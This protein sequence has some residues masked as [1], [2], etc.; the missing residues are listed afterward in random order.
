M[1]TYEFEVLLAPDTVMDEDLADRLFE[2]GCDDGLPGVSNGVPTVMF[3][4]EAESL[5]SAIRTA[6]ADVERAGC[7]VAEVRAGDSD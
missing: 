6:V 1:Q 5:E 2:A 7:V 4:R 3:A